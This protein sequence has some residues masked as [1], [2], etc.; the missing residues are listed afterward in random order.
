MEVKGMLRHE[1]KYMVR[2]LQIEIIR[3]KMAAVMQMDAH[4][5]ESG[6][7][8]TSL[9]YDDIRDRFL[10]ENLDGVDHRDKYRIRIYNHNTRLIKLEKKS[11]IGT[12]C[13]KQSAILTEEEC[14]ALEEAR[15]PVQ[16]GTEDKQ[17]LRL[18]TEMQCMQLQP[19][20][21]IEYERIAFVYPVGNVRIT[22]DRNIRVNYRKTLFPEDEPVQADRM[23]AGDRCKAGLGVDCPV[24]EDRRAILEVKYDE[25]LPGFLYNLLDMDVLQQTSFSKYATGRI[26]GGR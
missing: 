21:L 15:Y 18:L 6:Y 22:I 7:T 1:M 13:R 2:P 16:A 9:Y 20:C 14:R 19:K 3:Q 8:V 11:K 26:V 12:M 4:Q 24:L 23:S 25:L 10:H 17:K 5:T